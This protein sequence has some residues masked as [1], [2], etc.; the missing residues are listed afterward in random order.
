MKSGAVAARC[1][2]GLLLVRPDK[3][4]GLEPL[5]GGVMHYH[6]LGLFW[7]DTSINAA[8]RVQSYRKALK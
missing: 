7:V 4:L 1:E 3:A 5:A 6:D 2:S 8:L